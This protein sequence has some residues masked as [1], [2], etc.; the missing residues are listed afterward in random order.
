MTELRFTG[1]VRGGRLKIAAAAF[2]ESG[3]ENPH[4]ILGLLFKLD[5]AVAQQAELSNRHS[6]FLS[7]YRVA[8]AEHQ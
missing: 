7:W 3:L 2:L 5:V 4:Q 6:P 8:Q 1:L